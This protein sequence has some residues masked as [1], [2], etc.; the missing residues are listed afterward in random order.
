M[1]VP[2]HGGLPILWHSHLSVY[3]AQQQ[4]LP[5]SGQVHVSLLHCHY[6]H[7][8]PPHIYAEE[9][10]C[11]GSDEEGALEGLLLQM[12]AEEDSLMERL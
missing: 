7:D 1:W 8:Q 3:S 5:G 4:R 10:G 9:Q 6:P 2:P 11:E 12:I